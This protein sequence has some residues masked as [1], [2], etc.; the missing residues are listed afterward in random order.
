MRK[1]QPGVA[2]LEDGKMKALRLRMWGV[3]KLGREGLILP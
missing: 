3:W 2:D 1:S